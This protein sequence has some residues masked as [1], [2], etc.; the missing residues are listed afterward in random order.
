MY[1]PCAVLL[2]IIGNYEMKKI[3]ATTVLFL[4]SFL[5]NTQAQAQEFTGDT[6]YACEAILCLSTSARPSE[7]APSI[8]KFFSIWDKKPWKIPQKRFNFLQLCPVGE[9][10]DSFGNRL[11]GAT[12]AEMVDYMNVL[13]NGASI[14]SAN[15]INRT[16]Y[17]MVSVKI[18]W[19]ERDSDGDDQKCRVEQRKL[20]SKEMPKIC[21]SYVNHRLVDPENK[22][23]QTLKYTVH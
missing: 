1:N 9:A 8:A 13:A 15:Y 4:G 5:L 6:K 17:R 12:R 21:K 2:I 20:I 7:C 3:Y 23:L 16:N 22:V 10:Q 19:T 11:G 14:C 18:C